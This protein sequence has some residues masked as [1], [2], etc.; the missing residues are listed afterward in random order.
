MNILYI[1]NWVYPVDEMCGGMT[2]FVAADFQIYL[3]A[4]II[5]FSYY[6]NTKLGIMVNVLILFGGMF[7]SGMSAYVNEVAPTFGL[8]HTID[9]Q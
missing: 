7:S 8:Q 4:P 2:W 1:S 6:K 5:F 9:L 3:F